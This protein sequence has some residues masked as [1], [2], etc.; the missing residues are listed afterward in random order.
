VQLTGDVDQLLAS[1]HR[2]IGARRDSL[3]VPGGQEVIEESHTDKQTTLLVRSDSPIHDP[4][5][6]IRPITLDDLVLAYLGRD[7][8][9][10]SVR[11][12][13]LRV[14]S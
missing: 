6:T 13:R 4:S 14:A 8:S 12:P 2:L 3:S 10:R 7:R 1:H 11:E 5:W 9:T